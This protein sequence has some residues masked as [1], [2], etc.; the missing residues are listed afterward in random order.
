[1]V[2][3]DDTVA[4]INRLYEATAKRKQTDEA[5]KEAQ[6]EQVAAI[7]FA[8]GNGITMKQVTNITELSRGWVY[9]I[10]RNFC[11][12]DAESA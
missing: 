3:P 12:G 6:D 5:A 9:Q 10:R 4:A 8:F 11:D 7:C 1:M 2:N